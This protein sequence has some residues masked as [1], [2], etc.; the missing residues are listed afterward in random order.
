MTKPEQLLWQRIRRKQIQGVQFYRQ[1]PLLQFIVDFYA[2]AAD[3][4]IEVDGAQHLEPVHLAK[5]EERDKLLAG[6][7]LTVLRFSNQQI[8]HNL[9]VVVEE[10]K[11]EL[12]RYLG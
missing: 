11:Q 1:K 4:V 9:D 7:G 2:P 10:I 3:L 12:A 8:F 6:M 5:D